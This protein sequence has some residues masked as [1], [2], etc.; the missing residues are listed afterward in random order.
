M[1]DF[2][3]GTLRRSQDLLREKLNEAQFRYA[4]NRSQENHA[5]FLRALRAFSDLVLGAKTAR[6]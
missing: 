3:D 2:P 4:E 6:D 5:E 1:I